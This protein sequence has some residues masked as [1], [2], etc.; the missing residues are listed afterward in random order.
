M[1]LYFYDYKFSI[2]YGIKTV[3]FSAKN[4]GKKLYKIEGL[5]IFILVLIS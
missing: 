5:F 3:K 4:S 1:I 2:A